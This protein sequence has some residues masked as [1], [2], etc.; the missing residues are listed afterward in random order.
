MRD[1]TTLVIDT[2]TGGVEDHHPTIELAAIAVRGWEEVAHFEQRI[3]FD[4]EK[5][6][7]EALAMNSYDPKA[8]EDAVAP[9]DALR[10]FAFWCRDFAD[11]KKVSQRTGTPYNV[12]R[13][14]GWNVSF[15]CRRIERGAK[16]A[17]LFLP[18][19]TYQA[20][21]WLQIA[22]GYFWDQETR[23][24]NLRLTTVAE[25]FGIPTEGAHGALAD[26]RLTLAVARRMVS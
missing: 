6:D 20:L 7:P 13:V 22:R 3:R 18:A 24:D 16:G 12:A 8:W 2:E 4:V 11:L 25:F 19:D 21:D 9:M 1:L 15:D 5:C 17:G 14:S 26:C 23:P 10:A